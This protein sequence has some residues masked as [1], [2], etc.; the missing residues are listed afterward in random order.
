[1]RIFAAFILLVMLNKCYSSFFHKCP[2]CLEGNIYPDSNPYHLR[3]TARMFEHCP[4]CGLQYVPE[5]GY[6]YGAMYVS[7]AIT[8]AIAVAVFL[9]DYL[10]FWERG[11]LFF[12]VLLTVVLT[13]LAPYTFRTSRVIW[14]NFFNAYRPDI[15]KQ[16]QGKVRQNGTTAA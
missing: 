9:A 7:Y 14:M 8:V 2:Q 12:L 1:M 11:V 5:P 3:Q 13:L 6:F 4:R 10:F 15:R 16:V